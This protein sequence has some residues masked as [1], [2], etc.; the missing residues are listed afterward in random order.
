LVLEGLSDAGQKLLFAYAFDE[1]A[2]E[3]VELLDF[4]FFNDF[5]G[6]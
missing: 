2:L 3:D 4:G 1:F 6:V 5:H